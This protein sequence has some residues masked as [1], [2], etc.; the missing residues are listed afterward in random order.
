MNFESSHPFETNGDDAPIRVR[1]LFI[2]DIHLGT[3]GC[4]A[5]KFLD[6]L[7][8]S[9]ADLIY[10]VVELVDRW[11]L[12]YGWYLPPSPHD[13]VQ[14][15]LRKAR[16]GARIVYVTGNHDEVMRDFYGIHFGGIEVVEKTIHLGADGKRYLIIHGDLFDV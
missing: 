16:K 10:L 1:T 9:A 15:L 12:K 4:Q 8:D 6:F 7:R 11:P 13:V 3:R 2:S 14:K 5:E